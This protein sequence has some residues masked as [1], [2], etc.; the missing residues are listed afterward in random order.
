MLRKAANKSSIGRLDE[1][2]LGCAIRV[3]KLEK[4]MKHYREE[5]W[6]RWVGCKNT[7]EM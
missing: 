1:L 6:V 4:K 7:F 3:L 5:R 2:E